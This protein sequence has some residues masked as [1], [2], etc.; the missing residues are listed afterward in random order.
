MNQSS[1]QWVNCGAAARRAPV[2]PPCARGDPLCGTDAQWRGAAHG[3]GVRRWPS[4]MSGCRMAR[5]ALL[6]L[7]STGGAS[8]PGRR[9]RFPTWCVHL[10]CSGDRVL[11]VSLAFAAG[12]ALAASRRA[13]AAADSTRHRP[14]LQIIWTPLQ[15]VAELPDAAAR[16][17]PVRVLPHPPAPA[18]HLRQ[19]DK[20][21]TV[22]TSAGDGPA[23]PLF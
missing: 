3:R 14:E 15:D 10:G 23:L 13:G 6:R 11:C 17:A 19:H 4:R 1:Y 16:Q 9:R 21:E 5:R 2:R 8:T 22:V 20:R 18:V 12:A 7:N